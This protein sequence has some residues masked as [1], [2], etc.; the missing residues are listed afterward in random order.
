VG[1]IGLA[2][3][4]P[5]TV[6]AAD[7]AGPR[8]AASTLSTRLGNGLEVVLSQARQQPIFSVAVRYRV[9]GRD[10]PQNLDELAHLVEHLSFRRSE[11]FV[12]D[13]GL[14]ITG[15][16]GV[17]DN[18]YTGVDDTTF[19][20]HGPVSALPRVL[21][22]E[23]QRMAF[24]LGSLSSEDIVSERKILENE[25]ST[26]RADRVGGMFWQFV[27][28]ELYPPEHP[29]APRPERGCILRCEL[30]HAQWLMQRGYRPDNARLV[31][32]GD[33]EVAP[34]LDSVRK[35]FGS[36]GNPGVSLPAVADVPARA[37]HRS[38]TIAAPVPRC[39]VHLWWHVPGTMRA[40]RRALDVLGAELRLL[41]VTDLV[42]GVGLA[43]DVGVGV[44]PRASDWLWSV[45]IALHPGVDPKLVERRALAQVARLRRETLPIEFARESQVTEL[46]EAWEDL[47]TRA[48]LLASEHFGFEIER[49][50]GEQSRVSAEDVRRLA[51]QLLAENPAL[52][53]YVRRAVDAPRRGSLYE[54]PR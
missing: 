35:L 42:D 15:L 50:K 43:S 7:E 18:A 47:D 11:H 16:S 39:R 36:I 14:R 34:V 37:E 9:G 33:F 20:S 51:G 44:V 27:S 52:S 41:L 24:A 48:E 29:Y 12:H 5:R 23:R 30:R 17:S 45:H 1:A 54:E 19:V 53:V 2:L 22:L 25:R 21:W 40:Q 38:I 8:L 28:A 31:V 13:G 26:M 46:L 32:V 4:A 49:A 3:T 10:D 6:C